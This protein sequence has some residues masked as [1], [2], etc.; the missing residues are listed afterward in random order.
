VESIT[1]GKKRKRVRAE[2]WVKLSIK[3]DEVKQTPKDVVTQLTEENEDLRKTI[4]EKAANLYWKMKEELTDRVKNFTQVGDKQQRRHLTQIQLVVSFVFIITDN[5]AT[6]GK[7]TCRFN[8]YKYFSHLIL[9]ITYW[10]PL[11]V[12]LKDKKLKMHCGLQ[13]LIVYCQNLCC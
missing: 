1:N 6:T 12:P 8:Y 13:K 7:F 3:P 11:F 5:F 2:T 10:L 4:D 9:I